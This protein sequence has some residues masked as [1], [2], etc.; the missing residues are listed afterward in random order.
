[1]ASK[2]FVESLESRTMLSAAAPHMIVQ[3]QPMVLVPGAAALSAGTAIGIANG[4]MSPS[5]QD[6]TDFGPMSTTSGASTR[7][8][9]IKNKGTA[10][11]NIS[12]VSIVGLHPGDFTLTKAPTGDIA[13]GGKGVILVAFKPAAAGTRTAKLVIKSNDPSIPTDKFAIAGQGLVTNDLPDGLQW[14][15]TVAGSGPK[16]AYNTAIK[17]NYRGYLLNGVVFDPGTAPITIGIA[18]F[19]DP[20]V[21]PQVIDGWNEGL[22]GMRPGEHRT[23]II[24]ASLGYGGNAKGNIPPNSTL[25]FDTELVSIL[26]PFP[27]LTVFSGAGVAI[28]SGTT[29]ASAS[30]GTTFG[31]TTV[32]KTVSRTFLLKTTDIENSAIKLNTISFAKDTD[33]FS[34]SAS[35]YDSTLGGWP[36]TITYH[37]TAVGIAD[38]IVTIF[39]GDLLHPAY[40]FAIHAKAIA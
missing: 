32:G 17:V 38:T 16:T 39:S 10:A 7:R 40:T 5:V 11:L 36:V 24:P 13:P 21:T 4:D 27:Y 2:V 12:S 33:P 3:A 26:G 14:A 25:I 8:Y 28:P 23:L 34:W 30:L 1:M 9:V 19:T 22:K 18:D 29:T 31:K 20:A 15:R 37:A 6:D 35:N